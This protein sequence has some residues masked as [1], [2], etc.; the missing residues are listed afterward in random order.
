[1]SHLQDEKWLKIELNGEDW[2]EAHKKV[3]A[4]WLVGIL[5][6][7]SMFIFGLGIIYVRTPIDL[8]TTG[9]LVALCVSAIFGMGGIWVVDRY[10]QLYRELQTLGERN[11]ELVLELQMGNW[12]NPVK[13]LPIAFGDLIVIDFQH[14]GE[15]LLLFYYHQALASGY[16]QEFTFEGGTPLAKLIIREDEFEI[17]YLDKPEKARDDLLGRWL[18]QSG[19]IIR[20]LEHGRE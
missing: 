6:F 7:V 19:D 4:G 17:M 9:F 18:Y 14:D 11:R 5:G 20:Q 16:G 10:R 8:N 1:M 3:A 12:N 15:W 2:R 13:V